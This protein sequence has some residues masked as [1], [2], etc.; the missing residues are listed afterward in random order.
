METVFLAGLAL[1]TKCNKVGLE[2]HLELSRDSFPLLLQTNYL[3]LVAFSSCLS[4]KNVP[5]NHPS[6]P[7]PVPVS[8]PPIVTIE[9][10][11][12]RQ[13]KAMVSPS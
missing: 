3:G 4:F 9:S 10:F 11:K 2:L 8:L 6:V 7:V 5:A 1:L 12:T 13:P